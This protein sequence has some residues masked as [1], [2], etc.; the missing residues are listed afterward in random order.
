[1]T[2]ETTRHVHA[3][4][5]PAWPRTVAAVIV[6]APIV[7]VVAVFAWMARQAGTVVRARSAILVSLSILCVPVAVAG[8]AGVW[9]AILTLAPAGLWLDHLTRTG[10]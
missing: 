5:L 3:F 9:W 8:L 7:A 1:V 6:R 10:D 4:A 2:T